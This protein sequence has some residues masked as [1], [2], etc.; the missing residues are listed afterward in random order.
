[1]SFIRRE[2]ALKQGAVK[3]LQEALRDPER[4]T[5]KTLREIGVEYVVQGAGRG[6]RS[7]LVKRAQ[8]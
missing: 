8:Q 2:L 6:A 7:F 1:M 4:E 3:K 5:T